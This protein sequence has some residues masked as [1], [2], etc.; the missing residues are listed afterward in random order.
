MTETGISDELAEQLVTTCRTAVGDTIRSV[1][2]FTPDAF[3]LL[4]I[5]NDLY[6]GDRDRARHAKE[7]LVE[8]ERVGFTTYETYNELTRNPESEPDMG[9]YEF[10]IRV[11]SD[12]FVNRAI[13]GDHGVVLTSNALNINAF[14]ELAVSLRKMLTEHNPP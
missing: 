7:K 14:E 4:Y 1:I 10:T 6:G 3:D 8:N 2:Y 5:R 13:V 9:D 12:G 11:F